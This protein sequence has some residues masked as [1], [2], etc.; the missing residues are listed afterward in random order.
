MHVRLIG[1]PGG[2]WVFP[3]LAASTAANR[4]MYRYLIGMPAH[5]NRGRSIRVPLTVTRDRMLCRTRVNRKQD[6]SLFCMGF[7]KRIYT[8]S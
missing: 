2:T 4:Q 1:V 3:H 8:D 7:P 5:L 6:E